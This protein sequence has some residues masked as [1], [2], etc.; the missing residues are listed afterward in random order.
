MHVDTNRKDILIGLLDWLYKEVQDDLTVLGSVR[1]SANHL[2]LVAPVRY[3][4]RFGHA[5]WGEF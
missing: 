3:L 5:L 4:P 1:F 2:D